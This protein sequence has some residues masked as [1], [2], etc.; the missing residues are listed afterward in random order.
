MCFTIVYHGKN[1]T[2]EIY[3]EFSVFALKLYWT[4]QIVDFE[5]AEYTN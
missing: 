2:N 5:H 1:E 3:G 4:I